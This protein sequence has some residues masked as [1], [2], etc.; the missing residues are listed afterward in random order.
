VAKWVIILAA[1]SV[2]AWKD[3]VGDAYAEDKLLARLRGHLS[4]LVDEIEAILGPEFEGAIRANLMRPCDEARLR[5]LCCV[6]SH[7]PSELKMRWEIGKGVCGVAYARDRMVYGDLRELSWAESYEE[8]MDETGQVAYGLSEE[9]WALT[10]NLET[11][12]AIP[13]Y[14]GND[15]RRKW[16]VLCLDS[17]KAIPPDIADSD[18]A[19]VLETYRRM[20]GVSIIL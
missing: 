11:I 20:F 16:G 18:I 10:R 19:K 15:P 2:Q 12:L 14:E 4:T 1:I 5:I 6:C 9:Q 17:T 13:I 8:L 7:K 3:F